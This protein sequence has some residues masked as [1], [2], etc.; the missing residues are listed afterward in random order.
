VLPF[1]NDIAPA[2][3]QLEFGGVHRLVDRQLGD[4][5][6][7]NADTPVEV[8]EVSNAT[9]ITAGEDHACGLLATGSIQCWGD[10]PYG[11]L[12]DGNTTSTDTPVE[13]VGIP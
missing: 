8:H 3:Q 11:Q 5:N 7:T 2:I 12:G 6:T 1:F 10:N 4:G 9:Q 13:M